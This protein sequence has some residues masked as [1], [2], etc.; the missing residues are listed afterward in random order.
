[1][2][3]LRPLRRLF[4]RNARMQVL[5]KLKIRNPRLSTLKEAGAEAQKH[6]WLQWQWSRA[7]ENGAIDPDKRMSGLLCLGCL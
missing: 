5:H 2:G 7:G 3:S 4:T 6:M 1:M